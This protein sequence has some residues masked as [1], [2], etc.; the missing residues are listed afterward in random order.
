[1]GGFADV[2]NGAVI[3]SLDA[4]QNLATQVLNEGRIKMSV[5]LG[6]VINIFLLQDLS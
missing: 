2:I 1:M 4:H 3:D 5:L 6:V